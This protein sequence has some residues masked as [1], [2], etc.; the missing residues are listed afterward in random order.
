MEPLFVCVGGI[1]I[2]KYFVIL[3]TG[4]HDSTDKIWWIS[5]VTVVDRKYR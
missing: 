2:Q 4:F 1:F 5:E 3:D